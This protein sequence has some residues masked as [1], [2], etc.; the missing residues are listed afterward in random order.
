MQSNMIEHVVNYTMFP[1]FIIPLGQLPLTYRLCPMAATLLAKGHWV[2]PSLGLQEGGRVART[3]LRL[4]YVA[5]VTPHG[6]SSRDRCC[7]NTN[8]YGKTKCIQFLPNR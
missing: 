6:L 8:I 5:F 3:D 7:L 4:T 2:R 1:C